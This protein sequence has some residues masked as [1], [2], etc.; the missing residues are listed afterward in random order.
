[1]ESIS[2]DEKNYI[3]V[4]FTLTGFSPL[5]VRKIFDEEFH[6]K[7]LKNSLSQEYRK[8]Q[9]LKN[10]KIINQ[11]QMDLLYPRKGE[12]FCWKVK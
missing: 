4:Q 8:I 5:V 1:M 10:R 9:Q 12:L 11:T 7:R 6:P 2:D 3:I